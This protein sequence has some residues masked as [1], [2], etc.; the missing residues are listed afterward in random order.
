M[1]V[2]AEPPLSFWISFILNENSLDFSQNSR[3]DLYPIFICS[4]G[5]VL[6][7][8][9]HTPSFLTKVLYYFSLQSLS[10]YSSPMV[11]KNT[12]FEIYQVKG[13]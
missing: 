11:L 13:P 3:M 9:T 1:P 12:P 2:V 4:L 7:T 8:S 5:S 6:Y 10:C